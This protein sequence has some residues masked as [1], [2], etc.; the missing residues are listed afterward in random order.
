M[1]TKTEQEWLYL[2]QKID[3][4]SKLSE[5]TKGSRQYSLEHKKNMNIY[6]PK[7]RAPNYVK[8][9][10]TRL[11]GTVDCNTIIV[12]DINIPLPTMDRSSKQKISEEIADL[13][14]TIDHM[15]LTGMNIISSK[16]NR[17][18]TVLKHT[19]QIFQERSCEVKYKC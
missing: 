3:F 10:L 15:E 7:T 1:V 18:H 11:K 4:K 13:N 19:W 12:G 6:S 17:K 8:Q 16:S 14:N 9:K 5:R 2:Y